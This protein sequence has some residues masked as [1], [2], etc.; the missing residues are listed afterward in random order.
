M[1]QALWFLVLV[2][3]SPLAVG[4]AA[5]IPE[6]ALGHTRLLAHEGRARAQFS[7]GSMYYH[8]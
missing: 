5:S 3:L 4:Y 8:G 2:S 1:K 7:L 6:T